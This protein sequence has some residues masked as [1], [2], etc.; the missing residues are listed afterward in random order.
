MALRDPVHVRAIRSF[1]V[2]AALVAVTGCS[3]A[4]PSSG[5]GG[6]DLGAVVQSEFPI[7]GGPML[8]KSS[9]NG[10]CQNGLA[11][12]GLTDAGL[13]VEGVQTDAFATWFDADPAGHDLLMQYVVR[14]A[15][16]GSVVVEWTSPHSNVAYAWAGGLGLASAWASGHPMT[17]PEQQLVSACL[18]AHVN[19]YGQ[20]VPLSVEGRA[21][22][23]DAVALD[24]GELDTFSVREGCFFGNLFAGE[25]VMVGLDHA[26]YDASRSS[27]RACAF[28][29]QQDGTTSL[30]CPPMVYAG[31]CE[32]L[33]VPTQDPLTPGLF[34]ETC[35]SG[36]KTYLPV[37]TRIRPA[38]VYTCGDGVCQV[39]ESCGTG[40]TADSC[41]DDCG[42]CP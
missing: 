35:T 41:S 38:D 11:L 12:A 3:S 24:P 10:I 25:P 13:G 1:A 23:G 22:S 16:P 30:A 31:A 37:T 15:A 9:T 42:P 6:G 19:K 17:E 36:G 29:P 39:S 4:V 18:A 32:A 20:S 21:A 7:C 8:L 40:H 34:Y 26:A 33:C 14:C 28:S 27:V 5:D 2:G